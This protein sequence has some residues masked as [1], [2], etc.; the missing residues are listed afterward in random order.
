MRAM[1]TAG[2]A[3]RLATSTGWMQLSPQTPADAPLKFMSPTCHTMMPSISF[4]QVIAHYGAIC[5]ASG[6]LSCQASRRLKRVRSK[7]CICLE[8]C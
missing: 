5:A 7:R 8:S 4:E 1:W 6:R 3:L 2:V